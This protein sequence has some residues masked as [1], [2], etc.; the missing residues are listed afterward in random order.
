MTWKFVPT[1]ATSR[2]RSLY[3]VTFTRSAFDHIPGIGGATRTAVRVA[4][5]T[6]Q[7]PVSFTHN[8]MS[9]PGSYTSLCVPFV[10]TY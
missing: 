6:F 4:P 3:A 9:P 7:R 1:F 2:E 5:S 8:A 10:W